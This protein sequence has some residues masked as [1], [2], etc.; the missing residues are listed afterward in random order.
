MEP[1][2]WTN[3]VRDAVKTVN[4]VSPDISGNVVVSG[5]PDGIY[6]TDDNGTSATLLNGDWFRIVTDSSS[7]LKTQFNPAPSG[8]HPSDSRL[9]IGF[10]PLL[11]QS[12]WEVLKWNSITWAPEWAANTLPVAT[13]Y[14]RKVFTAWVESGVHH[15]FS[16]NRTISQFYDIHTGQEVIPTSKWNDINNVFVTFGV[17][18][19]VDCMCIAINL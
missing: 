11:G 13:Y 12:N 6:L 16:N 2:I 18:C 17:D 3:R 1:S 9:D 5:L 10:D 15:S 7:V 4:G 19:T 8:L 14:E